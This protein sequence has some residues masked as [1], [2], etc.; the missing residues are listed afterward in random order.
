M[1]TQSDPKRIGA[2]WGNRPIPANWEDW[3]FLDIVNCPD[4]E[5]YKKKAPIVDRE[6]PHCGKIEKWNA[7]EA[8]AFSACAC[9]ECIEEYENRGRSSKKV[10][11]IRDK[12]E[13]TIPP[14]YLETD[15]ER[16]PYKQ[17]QEVM[18]WTIPENRTK[19]KGL[20]IVGD[21]RTSKTRTMCLLLGKLIK[22]GKSV[23]AFFHGAFGD[24]L[25]EVIRSEK[26]FRAWKREITRVDVLV[27][28]DLF[29]FK[30]TE[31]V[32]ASIFEILDE[33]IAWH[34]P[35]IVTTQLT[36]KDAQSR[37]QSMKRWEA[38]FARIKEFFVVVRT[39]QPKQEDMKL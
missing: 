22:Q 6:C 10:E 9:E 15:P 34:R 35:T 13:E 1:T 27:I 32:E 8:A 36:K 25:I 20:W 3:D 16:L 18:S 31:R 7:I 14:L 11:Q 29:S 37:F 39:T 24:Q 21:T 5:A 2:S 17:R 12:L 38:F 26:S 4:L 33:R 30:M 28:D 23:R 19:T